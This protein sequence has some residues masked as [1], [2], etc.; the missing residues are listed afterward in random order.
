MS[1]TWTLVHRARP[2]TENTQRRWHHHQRAAEVRTW[3]AAFAVLAF[4]ARIPHLDAIAV[5]AVPHLRDHRR[6]DVGACFPAVKAAID[7][8]C[9]ARV[10]PGDGPDQLTCLTFLAPICGGEDALALT[11]T[12]HPTPPVVEHVAVQ[13]VFL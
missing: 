12:D 4:E 3:R 10:I 13:G 1:R 11:I 5:V 9:D 6:Q 2:F 8:L 7:G